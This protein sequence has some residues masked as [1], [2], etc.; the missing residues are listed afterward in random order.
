MNTDFDANSANLRE[1]EDFWN[2]RQ[3]AQFASKLFHYSCSSVPQGGLRGFLLSISAVL[4]ASGAFAQPIA[5]RIENESLAVQYILPGNYFSLT[6]LRSGKQFVFK[7]TFSEGSGKPTVSRVE[8][9]IFGNGEQIEIA[10]PDGNKDTV[11]VFPRLP[12]AL[13]RTSLHNGLQETMVV[14]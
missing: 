11:S 4:A 3:L 10:Y 9:K 7:G 1:L 8:H 14:Q 2:S 13:F 5:T 6:S 12:F